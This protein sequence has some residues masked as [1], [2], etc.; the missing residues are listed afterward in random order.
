MMQMSS[1]PTGIAL[2]DVALAAVT[3]E[4]GHIHMI[5]LTTTRASASATLLPRYGATTSFPRLLMT[6]HLLQ[7]ALANHRTEERE[8][9]S[10]NVDLLSQSKQIGITL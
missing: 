1:M 6:L 5:A 8:L 9:L 7:A 2:D 3:M 10:N 4:K